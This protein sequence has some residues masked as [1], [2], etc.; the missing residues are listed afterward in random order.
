M[1]LMLRPGI[2][3]LDITAGAVGS[4]PE[5]SL[6]LTW[7]GKLMRLHSTLEYADCDFG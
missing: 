2:V 4:A 7:E 3:G 1:A 6:E 5:Q